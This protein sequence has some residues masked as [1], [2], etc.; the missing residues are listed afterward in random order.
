VEL[1]KRWN[2]ARRYVAEIEQRLNEVRNSRTVIMCFLPECF[3]M[4]ILYRFILLSTIDN[5]LN[6]SQLTEATRSEDAKCVTIVIKR[7][8]L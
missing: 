4:A 1:E 7:R 3:F 6:Y 8:L 5:H 2:N